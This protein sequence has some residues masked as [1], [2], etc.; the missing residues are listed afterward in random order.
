MTLLL[1]NITSEESTEKIRNVIYLKIVPLYEVWAHS[2]FDL[3]SL[4]T[5]HM[6]F[7]EEQ[8]SNKD[9]TEN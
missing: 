7:R 1:I 3:S 2:S 6:T 5:F 4:A 8:Y 9:S